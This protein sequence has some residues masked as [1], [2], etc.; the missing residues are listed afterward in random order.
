MFD[1]NLRR[2]EIYAMSRAYVVPTG[3]IGAVLRLALVLA[4]GAVLI[5]ASPGHVPRTLLQLAIPLAGAA[6]AWLHAYEERLRAL[7]RRGVPV[8]TPVAQ[9]LLRV[10]GTPVPS[11]AGVLEVAG[12]VSMLALV[13]FPWA[14]PAPAWAVLAASATSLAFTWSVG[15]GVMLD[16]S[17]YN[18]DS[19]ANPSVRLF[20]YL[21]PGLAALL[22][23]LAYATTSA[24]VLAD[25]AGRWTCALL[26]AGMLGTLYLLTIDYER[27]LAA[28]DEAVRFRVNLL[29]RENG[30]DVHS[31]V[32]NPL[33]LLRSEL[34]SSAVSV[35]FYVHHF[36][37]EVRLGV[38]EAVHAVEEGT[39][40]GPVPIEDLARYLNQMLSGRHRDLVRFGTAT[41]V[42]AVGARDYGTVRAAVLDFVTNAV[43]AG[44]GKVEVNVQRLSTTPARMRV[45][46]RDDAPGKV[47]LSTDP[48]G[49]S[50]LAALG[51]L[52]RDLG[53]GEVRL[54]EQTGTSKLIVAE[55]N[56]REGNRA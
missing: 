20:R 15:R 18:V 32:K 55:W 33:H 5:P 39:E 8:L 6:A 9:H 53:A 31:L 51:E 36:L 21:F 10:G 41:N 44:A 50:S 4:T 24:A 13:A 12:A 11:L 23:L 28:A 43:K 19:P 3:R 17:W 14:L 22:A 35:G 37:D 49:R 46:V 2:R 48:Q 25:P 1:P 45:S 56:S 40:E 54:D 30:R 47:Y 29:R 38:E 27:A 52:L 7:V 16:A 42:R 34:E 26:A